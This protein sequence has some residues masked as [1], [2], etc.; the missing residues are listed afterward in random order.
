[1]AAGARGRREAVRWP[2]AILVLMGVLAAP[3]FGAI[4][5]DIRGLEICTAEK[6]MARRTSCLQSNVELLQQELTKQ[7]RRSQEERASAAKEIAGLK[8]DLATLKSA[9]DKLKADLA[10]TKKATQQADKDKK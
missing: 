10:E 7:S 2:I 6:D 8:A 3:V 5:Q 1:V 4:A 9:L